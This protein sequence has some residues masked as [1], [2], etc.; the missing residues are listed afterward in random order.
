MEKASTP[1]F[2]VMDAMRINLMLMKGRSITSLVTAE[3]IMNP[4]ISYGG[5]YNRRLRPWWK[6]RRSRWE[7]DTS[8]D[9][10]SQLPG[11]GEIID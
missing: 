7:F 6:R 8:L 9:K 2:M 10:E 1:R 5:D 4:T 3:A 11:L